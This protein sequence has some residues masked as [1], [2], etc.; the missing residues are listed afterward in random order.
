[1][2]RTNNTEDAPYSDLENLGKNLRKL[3]VQHGMTQ[4]GLAKAA[5]LNIR[6]L[7]RIEAGET[8]I[9]VTTA[10]RLISILKC[11]PNDLLQ[12]HTGQ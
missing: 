5:D 8:N 9:L 3:R 4:A 10:L 11:T 2:T 1:M 7:Q 12:P 6:T